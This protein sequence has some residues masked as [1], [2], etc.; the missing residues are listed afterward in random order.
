MWTRQCKQLQQQRLRLASQ[1]RTLALT[2]G[3]R[4]SNAWW[5]PASWEVLT[6]RL[7]VNL[8]KHLGIFRRVILV[9]EEEIQQLRTEVLAV[10]PAAG[11]PK[12]AGD[13]SLEVV[14]AEVCDWKRFTSWRKAGS[15]CGLTGGVSAS[16]QAHA[17]LSITKAGNRRLRSALV[18]MAW[19]MVHHQPGY[20]LT[21]KWAPILDPR[22]KGHRRS[23]KKAI[24]A[25]AR[26]LFIDLWKW[27]TGRITAEA[28]GWEMTG[29]PSP[30]RC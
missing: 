26:Q 6:S 20:W 13:W 7:S 28:L 24:V 16:G 22:A 18:E 1:G 21:R 5:Q 9:V 3:V 19:R 14:E 23:R 15:Y 8:V 30:V 10:R 12:Y 17:D 29:A 2:Q 11:Q 27:K 4:L 25:Y